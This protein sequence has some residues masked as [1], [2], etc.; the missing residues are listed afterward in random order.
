MNYTSF[1]SSYPN[2]RG[3]LPSYP[4]NTANPMTL[5]TYQ[6][7]PQR[8]DK[9]TNPATIQPSG[10]EGSGISVTTALLGGLALFATGVVSTLVFKN[11]GKVSS[12]AITETLP[13]ELEDVFRKL[14]LQTDAK[15]SELVPAI[16]KMSTQHND[17]I[18]VLQKKLTDVEAQLS[19]AKK[20]GGDLVTLKAEKE[21][22]TQQLKELRQQLTTEQAS[23][24]TTKQKLTEERANH[25]NTTQELRQTNNNNNHLTTEEK[26]PTTQSV[27]TPE[28]SA[29]SPNNT[30]PIVRKTSTVHTPHS[31]THPL[32]AEFNAKPA[33][34]K[35]HEYRNH[36]LTETEE[37]INNRRLGLSNPPCC[38][39]THNGSYIEFVQ[40]NNTKLLIPKSDL[41]INEH[42]L[43]SIETIF[44]L[45][46]N[47]KQLVGSGKKLCIQ[48]EAPAVLDATN[49]LVT[50]GRFT[51]VPH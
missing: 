19:A 25:T 20:T 30:P 9:Q 43:G 7:P 31:A 1:N 33:A 2:S 13:K 28:N 18:Q 45:P 41:K 39:L 47:T 40:A 29:V 17:A 15:V 23:H 6:Q 44:E 50:K 14:E 46:P 4:S 37:S 48:L 42:N 34:Y 32:V 49:T 8:S 35:G 5:G 16:E 36:L 24:A 10:K 3:Y 51:L 22:L 11:K 38:E 12:N 26:Q 21:Q 27:N